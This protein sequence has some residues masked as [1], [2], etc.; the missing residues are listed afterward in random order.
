SA[1]TIEYIYPPFWFNNRL[2]QYGSPPPLFL[3]P[4]PPM[5]VDKI[6]TLIGG[7]SQGEG[8]FTHT[9]NVPAGVFDDFTSVETYT[10]TVSGD[11]VT[12]Q[13]VLTKHYNGPD[14]GS[15]V[16][17]D[18]SYTFNSQYDIETGLQS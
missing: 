14:F 13:F 12:E 6:L 11:T 3:S 4:P 9:E 1:S 16:I 18:A 7:V 5:S 17:G 10:L 15:T 8:T 2:P